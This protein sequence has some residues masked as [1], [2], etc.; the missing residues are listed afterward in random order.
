MFLQ[1]KCEGMGNYFQKAFFLIRSVILKNKSGSKREIFL[2]A[3]KKP[4]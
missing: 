1:E 3:K 4:R 2:L